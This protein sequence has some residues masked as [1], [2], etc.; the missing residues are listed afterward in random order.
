ML[1]Q[2]AYAL[3]QKGKQVMRTAWQHPDDGKFCLM[4][5]NMPM[6]WQIQYKPNPSAGNWVA[7]R[8]DFNASDWLEV[9]MLG[10]VK[11]LNDATV[12]VPVEA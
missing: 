10:D 4:I 11:V 9:E 8:E 5:Q 6:I 3:M 2:E 1:F 12:D 7:L